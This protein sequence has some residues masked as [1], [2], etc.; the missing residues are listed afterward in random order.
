MT[1]HETAEHERPN[2]AMDQA[3]QES[4]PASDPPSVAPKHAT[5][6]TEHESAQHATAEHERPN[7]AM[8]QALQESFPASDPPSV[9]PK[10]AKP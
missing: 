3:L 5:P 8:D 7:A 2:A 4:F 9:A 10:H 6:M 1:M